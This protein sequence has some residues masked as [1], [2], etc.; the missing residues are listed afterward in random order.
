MAV[1]LGADDLPFVDIGEGNKLKVI[2]VDRAEGLW[3]VENVFH[4]GYVVQT[5]RHTGP[6]YAYTTSGAWKYQEYDYVNRAGSFLFEPAGSVHTLESVEDDTRVWFQMYG[7]NLNLDAQGNIESVFDGP[8][9][10]E[11]YMALAEAEGFDPPR[12]LVS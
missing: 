9:T 7:V 8:G 6:V 5:H 3:I 1:H 4:A 12:V 10:L 11:A 2:Q